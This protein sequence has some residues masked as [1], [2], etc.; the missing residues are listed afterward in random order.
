MLLHGFTGS[1]DVWT[2]PLTGIGSTMTVIAP[3]LLGHGRTLA[4]DDPARFTIQ[5]AAADL[6]AVLDQMHIDR[7]VLHGYSMGGRLALYTALHYPERFTA[8]S[9]E[10]ASPGLA[11]PQERSARMA[12]DDALAERITAHG[13]E[14]FVDY[15]EQTP[16]FRHQVDTAPEPVRLRQRVIR[17]SQ[18][19]AGLAASLRGMGT[20]SQPSLWEQL[21]RLRMPVQIMSGQLDAKFEAIADEMAHRIPRRRRVSVPY[22]GHAVHVEAPDSWRAALIEFIDFVSRPNA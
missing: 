16:L 8:L 15:W 22:A 10:S 7:P 18:R 1:A 20:G 21:D 3:D 6:I 12:A 11:S 14:A 4:N 9:L 19:P 13:V 17:L 5:H 2:L